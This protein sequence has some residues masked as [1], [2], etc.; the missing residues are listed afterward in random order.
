M[1]ATPKANTQE[2]ILYLLFKNTKNF[3]NR[4]MK[5]NKPITTA[6]TRAEYNNALDVFINHKSF[7]NFLDK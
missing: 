2:G 7:I 3:I 4:H 5:E 6:V 1:I